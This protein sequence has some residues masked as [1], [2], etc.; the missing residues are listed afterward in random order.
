MTADQVHAGSDRAA[1][2]G[3]A[4]PRRVLHVSE[5]FAHGVSRAVNGIVRESP[6]VEHHLLH[7]GEE[8][9][10]DV[11]GFATAV[12]LPAGALARIRAVRARIRAVDPD[13]VHLHSSWAGV[14][15]RVIPRR[16]PVIYQPHCYAF[17]DPTRSALRRSFFRLAER[18]LASRTDVVVAV[19]HREVNL[20]SYLGTSDVRLVPN[21]S[22][23]AF[24][25]EKRPPK[26]RYVVAMSGRVAH[27][28][29]PEM[30][31][32][33]AQLASARGLPLDF[34]WLGTG[35]PEAE[36]RL[37]DAGV[38]VTGWLDIDQL[39]VEMDC[40]DLYLHTALYEGFPLS[41]LDAAA[42]NLPLLVREATAYEGLGLVSFVSAHE[43]TD[44]LGRWAAGDVEQAEALS[45]GTECIRR[46]FNPYV[47]VR[48]VRSLYGDQKT[49]TSSPSTG[50]V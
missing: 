34:V 11:T 19:S 2:R 38:R 1:Q 39:M 35:D 37:A 5:S 50:A 44:V 13:M 12:A 41:I 22:L 4:R 3:G 48:A 42:R 30:F 21:Q 32:A 10:P 17:E 18:A 8:A 20:A 24:G 36:R 7:T 9:D 27:Q 40:A 15:G 49:S 6:H 43:A 23:M 31:G 16:R 29:D 47:A 45:A 25:G 28:K 26:E 33:I 46:E 14:Y